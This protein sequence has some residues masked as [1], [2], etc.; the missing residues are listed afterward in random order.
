MPCDY[1]GGA[2]FSLCT[3]AN[4]YT[5]NATSIDVVASYYGGGIS[6]PNGNPVA[7]TWDYVMALEIQEQEDFWKA[8]EL[9]SGYFKHQTPVK[10]FYLSGKKAGRYRV[11]MYYQAREN[12]EYTG[13]VITYSFPVER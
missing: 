5:K 9:Q 12:D 8:V 13:S 4:R 10:K 3:D 2:I 1:N 7:P 6:G 11:R